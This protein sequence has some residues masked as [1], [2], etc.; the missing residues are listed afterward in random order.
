MLT[1][2]S[3]VSSLPSAGGARGDVD[4]LDAQRQGVAEL[5][6][7]RGD[8]GV[9]R[10]DH[11]DRALRL[12]VLGALLR[13]VDHVTGVDRA[14]PV[15]PG[16][17]RLA[18]ADPVGRV[19]H[20]DRGQPQVTLGRVG[21]VSADGDDRPAPRRAQHVHGGAG[22]LGHVGDRQEDGGREQEN[23]QREHHETGQAAAVHAA[24][25]SFGDQLGG[26]TGAVLIG[27]LAAPAREGRTAMPVLRSRATG[28][29]ARPAPGCS[30]TMAWAN[31]A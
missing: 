6:Q 1:I 10:A 15:E 31:F 18:Q 16:R 12:D 24:T 4:D 13:R 29:P 25:F 20:R 17:H 23:Q 9:L 5:V 8:R 28:G 30:L 27:V 21:L 11:V 3:R 7:R 22:A 19:R 2:R 14:R 26:A